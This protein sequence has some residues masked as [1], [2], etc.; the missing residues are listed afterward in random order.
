LVK[1]R[2]KFLVFFLLVFSLPAHGKD[3][4]Y[5]ELSAKGERLN[6]GLAE[7]TSLKPMS[8]E[9][10]QAGQMKDVVKDDLAF[11][12][13]FN[14]VEGGGAP[15]QRKIPFDAWAKLKTDVL[16]TAAY[17]PNKYGRFEFTGGLYDVN[18]KQL[19]LEKRFMGEVGQERRV[20][21]QWADEVIRHFL[22]QPGI[23]GTRVFFVNDATGKKEVCVIDYDG[24]NFQRLTNDRSISLLPKISPDG[25]TLV[26]TSYRDGVPNLYLLDTQTKQRR[27]LARYEGLNATAAWLPDG[28]SLI[29]TLSVG[30]DPN[31]YLI[32]LNGKIIRA[33]TNSYSVDTA[34]TISPDGRMVAFTSDRGG[35]PEIYTM[36]TNG[37]NIRRFS[38]SGECDSPA[39]APQGT[40][41]AFAMSA[42]GG[43][44]D[45]YTIEVG[46]GFQQ[47][48]TYGTGNSENPSW[49]PDGRFIVFSTDRRGRY[50]LWIMGIDGS[51]PQPL[52]SL[53][54]N[55]ITPYWAPS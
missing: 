54:G 32:D 18:S 5:L 28:Q 4:L 50:E 44:Y 13:L 33:L 51:N 48:L 36:D 41:V 10:A 22:G 8:A 6:L 1:M 49:S 37:A 47:R 34:P 11:T 42:F 45:I 35:K 52:A 53:P 30:R 7:F 16:V 17:N 23:A 24:Q 29:A 39:W 26:Y 40:L 27:V 12:R 31:L 15:Q 3:A 2:A 43:K 25:K 46:S 38:Q 21:H 55:S 9:A 14:I 20:A 19:I